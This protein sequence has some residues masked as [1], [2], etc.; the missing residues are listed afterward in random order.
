MSYHLF[1][2][3]L[4]QPG[5]VYWVRLPQVP[6][7]IVRDYATFVSTVER[8]GLPECVS[9]DHDLAHEHYPEPEAFQ[10]FL[11]GAKAY[12]YEKFKEKTGFHCAK[13][14][15]EYC[16]EKKLPIPRY[17]VHTQNLIGGENII[18]ILE[19]ARRIL[20][21]ENVIEQ[22]PFDPSAEQARKDL[23]AME[24]LLFNFGDSGAKPAARK[25]N[26]K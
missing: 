4:R 8:L 18:S 5:D 21:S 10:K 25:L 11:S 9:F 23:Q 22:M 19:N 13:W 15:A 12:S 26:K 2:D 7:T 6:W 14:L 1:L 20:E 16:V 17:T 3:D 24:R